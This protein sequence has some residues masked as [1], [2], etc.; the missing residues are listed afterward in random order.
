M[1][2]F[3]VSKLEMSKSSSFSTKLVQL[4]SKSAGKDKIYRTVQY[5]CKL[6]WYIIWKTKSN[7]DYIEILKRIE[8]TMSMTRKGELNTY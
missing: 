5:A 8:S 4:N 1:K 7:K 2:A 6:A 3:I